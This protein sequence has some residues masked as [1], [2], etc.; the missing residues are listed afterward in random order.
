MFDL[1]CPE[2]AV[3]GEM[4]REGQRATGGK[5]RLRTDKVRERTD[6]REFRALGY[7]MT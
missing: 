4:V 3:A 6:R 7:L 5:V 1:L 2:V